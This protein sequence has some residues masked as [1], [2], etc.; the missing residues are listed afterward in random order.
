MERRLNS[1]KP[2]NLSKPKDAS[3]AIVFLQLGATEDRA[4]GTL[5]LV[6]V[7]KGVGH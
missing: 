5:N 2:S 7:L 1:V 3:E 6:R 4:D